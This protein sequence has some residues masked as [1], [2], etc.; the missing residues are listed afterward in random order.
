MVLVVGSIPNLQYCAADKVNSTDWPNF[1]H[2][3][4]IPSYKHR[5]STSRTIITHDDS[6]NSFFTNCQGTRIFNIIQAVC[7]S[8]FSF[9][10]LFRFIFCKTKLKFVKSPQN[11][12]DFVS[13][14]PFYV[15]IFLWSINFDMRQFAKARTALLFL[16]F[17]RIAKVFTIFKLARYFPELRVL[18]ETLKSAIR[19]LMMLV[20]FVLINL[21]IFSSI[22]YNFEKDESGTAFDS[23]PATFWWGIATLTTVGYGDMTPQTIGGKFIASIGCVTG[24]MVMALPVSVLVDHFTEAYKKIVKRTAVGDENNGIVANGTIPVNK[25]KRLN[26]RLNIVKSLLFRKQRVNAFK[27]KTHFV[28]Q[29]NVHTVFSFEFFSYYNLQNIYVTLHC[30]TVLN[31]YNR[32][33]NE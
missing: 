10:L 9:E 27:I 11:V 22:V 31:S 2:E 4:S 15:E 18:G 20:L 21:L 23:I 32:Q 6:S 33:N 7:I 17:M 26:R 19:E 25:T 1:D 3:Y 12:I 30:D 13:T 24:V 16:R 5:T 28:A 14:F 29:I 8:W